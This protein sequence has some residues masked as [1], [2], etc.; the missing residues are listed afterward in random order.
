MNSKTIG[1]ISRRYRTFFYTILVL[2]FASFAW[3]CYGIYNHYRT[4]SVIVSELAR[5]EQDTEYLSLKNSK[6]FEELNSDT[7]TFDAYKLSINTPATPE[8]QLVLRGRDLV[9]YHNCLKS[10]LED[11]YTWAIYCYPD[12]EP[13]RDALIKTKQVNALE[14]HSKIKVIDALKSE[15]DDALN[16]LLISSLVAIVVY[17]IKRWLALAI[18]GKK[19]K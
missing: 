18:A 11:R 4:R 13:T 7:K 2:C 1:A 10:L 19:S 16:F 9:K 14:E 15:R 12:D 3:S 8:Q 17:I 6:L 5:I